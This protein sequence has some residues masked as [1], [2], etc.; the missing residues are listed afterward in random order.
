M[1]NAK[2]ARLWIDADACPKPIRELI[3]RAALR[4]Q[5]HTYFV[6][7]HTVALPRMG[8]IHAVSV[9]SGADAADTYI[10]EHVK[11]KDLVITSDLPLASLVLERGAIVLTSRGEALTQ[12]NIG[13]RLNMRDFMETLRASGEHSRG[14]RPLHARDVQA[15]AN[16]FDRTM[17]RLS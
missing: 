12:D 16:A 11:A 9:P 7:N 14:A 3:V 2:T 15:F 8:F 13:P 6:A 4:T 1:T 17:A 5:T 10:V